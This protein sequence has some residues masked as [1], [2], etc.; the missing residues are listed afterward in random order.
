MSEQFKKQRRDRSM[1]H[2]GGLDVGLA[3]RE[4]NLAEVPGVGTHHLHLA[5][6]Q[7]G[8]EHQAIQPVGLHLAAELGLECSAK[9][10]GALSVKRHTLGG[11]HTDV[12]QVDHHIPVDL[13]RESPLV[14]GA[15][16]EV[17]EQRQQ[18]GQRDRPARVVHAEPPL[19]CRGVGEAGDRRRQ[20]A[21]GVGEIDQDRQIDSGGTGIVQLVVAGRQRVLQSIGHVTARPERVADRLEPFVAN[22]SSRMRDPHRCCS[23]DFRPTRRDADVALHGSTSVPPPLTRGD[24]YVRVRQ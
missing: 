21:P 2:D 4:P 5:R 11:A 23:F 7:L 6:R 14:E 3:E 20:V 12:V 8:R 17:V 19:S 16:A 22:S 18:I 9:V 13:E 15:Q 10:I 24:R 1:T